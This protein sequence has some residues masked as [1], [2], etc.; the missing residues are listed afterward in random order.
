MLEILE[1]LGA[2]IEEREVR[3][4]VK[5]PGLK[6]WYILYKFLK[7]SLYYDPKD[8]LGFVGKPYYEIY[9]GKDTERFLEHDYASIKD[10]FEEYFKNHDE[11]IETN[12][13]YFL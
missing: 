9:G 4:E 11:E 1:S 6:R 12:P 3:D 8:H 13:E 7:L 10:F 2:T 5:M